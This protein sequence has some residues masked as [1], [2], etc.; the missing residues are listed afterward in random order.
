MPTTVSQHL[1]LFC[2][3][4]VCLSMYSAFIMKSSTVEMAIYIGVI[5]VVAGTVF[6][7]IITYIII[8]NVTILLSL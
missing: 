5:I 4:Y 2:L 1:R 3:L 6:A 8:I 7:F